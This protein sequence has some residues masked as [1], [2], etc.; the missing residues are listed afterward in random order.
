MPEKENTQNPIALYPRYPGWCSFCRKSYKDI[1]PL[2]EGPDQVFI[3]YLCCQAC[4]NL[5]QAECKRL[6]VGVPKDQSP[7]S[8]EG[9]T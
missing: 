7:P 2:A 4:A 6:G 8:V 3:C 9:D 1:G 5:I